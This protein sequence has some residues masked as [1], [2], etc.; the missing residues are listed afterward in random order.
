MARFSTMLVIASLSLC[1]ICLPQRADAQSTGKPVQSKT[2]TSPATGAKA[3]KP[4]VP[5]L[6]DK[7]T[8]HVLSGIWLVTWVAR[9]KA[10]Q[11]QI[12]Q[13]RAEDGV[14]TFSGRFAAPIGE[15][16]CPLTGSVIDR[17]NV[18]YSDGIEQRTVSVSAL[19]FIRAQCKSSLVFFELFGLPSG[20]VLMTGRSMVVASNGEKTYEP[21]ALSRGK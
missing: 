2:T 21:I 5:Q 20:T 19:V 3:A 4:I 18:Q 1:A 13:V 14:T 12:S 8:Q 9:S 17:G 11:L 16:T 7:E 6:A 10:S 15:E